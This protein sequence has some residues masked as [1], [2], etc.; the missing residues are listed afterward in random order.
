[1]REHPIPQDIT[2]YK[3]HLVGNMTIKQFAE[4]FAGIILA[5][6]FYSSNLIAV[7]KYPLAIF[8]V[9]FGAMLAFVPIQERPL[10]HW[11]ITFLKVLYKPT[12]FFWKKQNKIPDAFLYEPSAHPNDNQDEVNLSPLRRKRI[13]EYLSSVKPIQR[14]DAWEHAQQ[15]QISSVLQ[16]FSQISTPSVQILSTQKKQGV[17]KPRL[18]T[19][20]RNIATIPQTP[21][22]TVVFDQS[23]IKLKFNS[24][25]LTNV[26]YAQAKQAAYI[27][28]QHMI[29]AQEVA[30]ELVIPEL[31]TI[32]IKN[33]KTETQEEKLVQDN[34]LPNE[35]IFSQSQEQTALEVSGQ[36]VPVPINDNLPFPNKP[37]QVNQLAGMVFN[38]SREILTGVIVEVQNADG[39]V[40]RA[41]KTNLLGQFFITTP[42]SAGSYYIN[43]EKNGYQFNTFG[44]QLADERIPPLEIIAIN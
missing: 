12:K 6:V 5:L 35:R 40:V 14:Q 4:L 3:F 26:K 38:Q 41:V 16:I 20:V 33:P 8:F 39:Q 18:K 19:R 30:T 15:Q 28:N 42:L 34:Y 10:D 1:M 13:Q 43:I 32:Q 21:Q 9:G 36:I 2:G 37:Q 17:V 27:S 24:Q 44:I 23:Q 22:E 31:E 29:D 11:V 25:N 7:I